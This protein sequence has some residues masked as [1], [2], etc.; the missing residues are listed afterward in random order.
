MTSTMIENTTAVSHPQAAYKHS[1]TPMSLHLLTVTHLLTL[2]RTQ[3]QNCTCQ[4]NLC[5]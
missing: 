5:V 1:R 2:Q 3:S 4:L